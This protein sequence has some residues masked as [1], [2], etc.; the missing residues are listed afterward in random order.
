MADFGACFNKTRT[1]CK[2]ATLFANP[3]PPAT[4]INIT[5]PTIQTMKS[6]TLLLLPTVAVADLCQSGRSYCGNKIEALN[7]PEYCAQI[8]GALQDRDPPF[9]VTAENI[10]KLLMVCG[11]GVELREFCFRGCKDNGDE[12]DVYVTG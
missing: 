6:F 3:Q 4:N 11:H 9:A 10:G 2:I 8:Q 12:D 1:V 7:N 5:K